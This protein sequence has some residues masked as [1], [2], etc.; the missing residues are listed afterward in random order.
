MSTQLTESG[1]AG[2]AP[3]I[4]DAEDRSIGSIAERA[5]ASEERC[6]YATPWKLVLV[7]FR[8]TDGRFSMF[9]CLTG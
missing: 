3:A 6:Y 7:R 1:M 4:D 5:E 9:A 8:E 2:G